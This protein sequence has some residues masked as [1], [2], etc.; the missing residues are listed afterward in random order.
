MNLARNQLVWLTDAAWA[1]LQTQPWDAEA[2]AVLAHWRA[3]QLP[4]VVC[5]QRTELAAQ[6]LGVGLP[7]PLQWSRRRLALTVAVAQITASGPF[8]TLA[9]VVEASA[10]SAPARA[11]VAALA[12]LGVNATVYGSHGWQELTGLAYVHASSDLDLRVA[13][14][15][16]ALAPPVLAL[17]GAAQLP[18]R[19]DG[20]VALPDG[21]AVAWRELQQFASGQVAQVLF[22]DRQRAWLARP[23]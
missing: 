11:L 22:K 21:S 20:E 19:L 9:K 2:Q 15:S 23:L 3:Q 13:L 4:L 12:A 1:Q 10:R 16:L 8:P 7:A 5:R 6:Q 17:L 14:P 18:Q